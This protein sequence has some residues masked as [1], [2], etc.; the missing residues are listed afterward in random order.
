MLTIVA[1]AVAAAVTAVAAGEGI[2]V[3]DAVEFQTVIVGLV[4]C[5]LSV[6]LGVTISKLVTAC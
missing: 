3:V 6:M 2:A 5:A 1:A 4:Q